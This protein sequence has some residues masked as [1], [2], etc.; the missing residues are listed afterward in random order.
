MSINNLP[1]QA[2]NNFGYYLFL[3][4]FQ[5]FIILIASELSAGLFFKYDKGSFIWHRSIQKETRNENLP[6]TLNSLLA[7]IER[8]GHDTQ[9]EHYLTRQIFHPYLGYSLRPGWG[10]GKLAY[11]PEPN[12]ANFHGFY[13]GMNF[14][15]QNFKDDFIVG[16]FGGSVAG[17]FYNVAKK[18][19]KPKLEKLLPNK[20]ITILSVNNGGYKQPQQLI[21]LSYLIAS[22]MKFDLVIN[23]D[24]LN[25]AYIGWKNFNDYRADPIN[26]N[27]DFSFQIQ[28]NIVRSSTAQEQISLAQ[29][30]LVKIIQAQNKTPLALRYY[31]F[32]YL[33]KPS[34]QE[35]LEYVKNQTARA[36]NKENSQYLI[37]PFLGK[38]IDDM[39]ASI[40]ESW[41]R[42]SK[43]MHAILKS[44]GAR[45]V[46]LL[47]PNQYYGNRKFSNE[48]KAVAITKQKPYGDFRDIIVGPTYDLMRSRSNELE[49]DGIL[50]IDGTP[51][52]DNTIKQVYSDVCCH[53]LEQGNLLLLDSIV[54]KI[55]AQIT[56]PRPN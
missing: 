32:E 36:F 7:P 40:V 20:K 17:G 42:S 26:P 27:V 44:S 15:D 41:L 54:T 55:K 50:F 43:M 18:H 6:D 24:G 45:Y 25:E 23:I 2:S 8:N 13:S 31:Y 3:F 39:R 22:G 51:L 14:E 47:Q 38:G 34:A 33:R 35:H 10:M 49:E 11:P 12:T 1:H 28:A 53:L 4:L 16:I 56:I 21:A 37:L 5:V 48:E 30:R 29:N 52:F 9:S 19:L 46:H